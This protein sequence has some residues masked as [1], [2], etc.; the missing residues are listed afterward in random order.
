MAIYS[1]LKGVKLCEF[2][3]IEEANRD[4]QWKMPIVT[5]VY[6]QGVEDGSRPHFEDSGFLDLIHMS[7]VFDERKTETPDILG[8]YTTHRGRFFSIL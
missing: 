8:V 6:Q 5:L 7:M 3:V 4:C 1:G 2:H